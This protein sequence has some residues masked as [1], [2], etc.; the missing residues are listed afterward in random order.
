MPTSPSGEVYCD[1]DRDEELDSE[2]VVPE[3]AGLHVGAVF[4]HV[5]PSA[6]NAESAF[7]DGYNNDDYTFGLGHEPDSPLSGPPRAM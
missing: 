7:N 4:G 2:Q 5:G 3:E 6:D 1:G